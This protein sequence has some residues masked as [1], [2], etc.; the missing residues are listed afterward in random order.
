MNA[1]S[2]G[3]V[4]RRPR[5]VAA[6]E[7]LVL[8]LLLGAARER[9]AGHAR[10]TVATSPRWSL[11]C[12]STVCVPR[13][14]S[15]GPTRTWSICTTGGTGRPSRRTR[16]AAGQVGCQPS[17]ASSA[18]DRSPAAASAPHRPVVQRRVEV[19]DHEVGVG[20]AH[21][22]QDRGVVGAPAGGVEREVGMHSHQRGATDLDAPAGVPRSRRA[23][24]DPVGCQREDHGAAGSVSRGTPT[25]Y[26]KRSARPARSIRARTG[27]VISSTTSRSAPSSEAA[28][29]SFDA[30]GLAQQHV[31]LQHGQRLGTRGGRRVGA[32]HPGG[33]PRAVQHQPGH[34]QG[35]Q[36]PEGGQRRRPRRRARRAPPSP[37]P[38]QQRAEREKQH[39][40]VRRQ[41]QRRERLDQHQPR[42]DRVQGADDAQQQR[43][44]RGRQEHDHQSTRPD[45]HAAEPR[46]SRS[47]SGPGPAA[48]S[49]RVGVRAGRGRRGARPRARTPRRGRA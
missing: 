16:P 7:R 48:A 18:T 1:A 17:L 32:A 37:T 40:G 5:A 38:A 11:P 45:S 29:T 42:R 30:V 35:G 21:R 28:R 46:A 15:P 23:R 13:A 44:Q 10:A 19:P 2:A 25:R 22:R 14:A 39:H 41:R 3:R 33:E 6:E 26:G 20:G 9:L 4:E 36:Q 24:P 27:P 49:P 43:G 8:G 34:G 12:R 47:R 31:R